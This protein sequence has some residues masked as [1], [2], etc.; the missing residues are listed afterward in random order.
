MRVLDIRIPP[1][2]DLIRVPSHLDRQEKFPDLHEEIPNHST[3]MGSTGQV[4]RI[5]DALIIGGGPAGLSAALGLCRMHR[6]TAVFSH[7]QFRNEGAIAMHNVASRDGQKPAEFRG[8]TREQ[9]LKYGLTDFLN[10]KI[11]KMYKESFDAFEGFEIK[12]QDGRIWRGRKLVMAMGS[13][14]IFPSIPG[15]VENWPHNM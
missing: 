10:T 1:L 3:M 2:Y 11:V 9:I 5:Y 8:T 14:D 15:Y 7:G 4:P 6:T 12:S 13:K